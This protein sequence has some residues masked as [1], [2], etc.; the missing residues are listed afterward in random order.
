MPSTER[1]GDMAARKLPQIDAV[2]Q[3]AQRMRRML[4]DGLASVRLPGRPWGYP[5]PYA[6][7][8]GPGL[9]LTTLLFDTLLWRVPSGEVRPWL[10]RHWEVSA[11]G[12]EH[13]FALR[14]DVRWHDGQSLTAGD[15]VFTFEYLTRETRPVSDLPQ[16]EGLE[17]VDDVTS[18][19][20]DEVTFRLKHAYAAFGAFVAGRV[21]IVPAHIWSTVSEPATLRGPNAVLGSGP[22][23]LQSCDEEAGSY[24]LR[25]NDAYFCG[26]P[27]LHS[28]DFVPVHDQLDA[29]A[30]GEIDAAVYVS[31][32][33]R[34][35]AEQLASV[36][37]PRYHVEARPGEWNRTLHFN[38]GGHSPF[39]D[40]RVRRAIAH[41]VDRDA[42]VRDLL[43]GL[44]SPGSPGGMAP[45]HPATPDDLPQYGHD[46]ETARAL[47]DAA[48]FPEATAG[49]VRLDTDGTP[50]RV[51]LLTD[52]TDPGA[53]EMM[54]RD[55][56]RIGIDAE[57]N[58]Y[59]PAKADAASADSRYELAL[60]G[61]G[62]LG[63]DPDVLRL[64][65]SRRLQHRGRTRAHG[66]DSPEFKA[67]AGKQCRTLNP[68]VRA[69]LVGQML[70]VVAAELPTLPLYV[71]DQLTI[72]PVK[73]VFTA[74]HPTQGGVWG[75]YPGPLNKY[76]F[77]TGRGPE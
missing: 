13:R 9:T 35:S 32:G 5:S 36:D 51:T 57:I 19:G 50:L 34:P 26:A 18:S 74:W 45:T 30:R 40:P 37:A 6:Y 76:S 64:R 70:R 1:W 47:L 62:G 42:M 72:S 67:L 24:R 16:L 66:Y 29:L 10:A 56:G 68:G 4:T 60:I 58:R 22:Y 12:R 27:Y 25:A 7:R 8:R 65:L 69:T 2:I 73:Q 43:A 21:P 38:L 49:G 61:Y 63:G 11:D 28:L 20:P 31:D 75:G 23:R 14:D 44:G 59:A 54:A 41:A 17:A 33:G 48:G 77:I 52:T 71:P 39:K 3:D 55:L 15:V 46:V 53:S